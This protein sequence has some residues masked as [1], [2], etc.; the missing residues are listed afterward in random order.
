MKWSTEAKVGAFALA[1]LI[2]FAAI[3]VQLSHLVLFGKDGFHVTGYFQ[4]AE[5]IERGNP[6]RYAGVE[7]GR[8]DDIL[9]DRGEAVLSL[10]FYDGTEVPKDAAFSI[11]SSGVMG[12][13][14]VRA[15]G[16]RLE[17]G[18]LEEGMSVHGAAAPGFETAMNKMD[19][20][21]DSAQQLLDGLNA[22]M[23][24]RAAQ[25]NMKDTIANI[26][27][28]TQNLAVLTAQ[29]IQIAGDVESMS[30]Q[31][32][33]MLADFNRDGRA[34]SQARVILDNLAAT[35]E[36]AKELSFRA[37]DL[38]GKLDGVMSGF[39]LS[40]EGELLYNTSEKEFSPNFSFRFGDEKFVRLG[41]ES[42]GE[43]SLLNAQYGVRQGRWDFYGGVIR[44]EVGTGADYREDRW[45]IGADIYD[46]NDLT[47]RIRGGYEVFPDI[48]A[49]VATIQPEKRK[50]G[51]N[52]V[53]LSYMY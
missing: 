8:V 10:R 15:S 3:I 36:N 25:N 32:N 42:L 37:R 53:G 1:G 41:V 50:G 23:A 45:R 39:Q 20:L 44:G 6:I 27:T 38:S 31:M 16:G 18:I 49:T 24:D 33:G 21:A 4:E 14:Y 13:M 28:L 29:G 17:D 7:V 35:S 19:R 22:V 43:D 2:I 26:N 51:G 11:Q 30:R 40:G 9:V 12:G 34:G 46:P 52:Y 5:G 47:V 48:F